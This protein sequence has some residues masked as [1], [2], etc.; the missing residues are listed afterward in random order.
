MGSIISS[1]GFFFWPVLAVLGASCWIFYKR[2]IFLKEIEQIEHIDLLSQ[3]QAYFLQGQLEKALAVTSQVRTPITNVLRAGLHAIHNGKSKEET[4]TA[5]DA[6]SLEE[7]PKL[8]EYN[9]LLVHLSIFSVLLGFVGFLSQG[10]SLLKTLP[11]LPQNERVLWVAQTWSMSLAPFY[12]GA[13]VS[14]IIWGGYSY[15]SW[16]YERKQDQLHSAALTV[17][18]LSLTYRDKLRKA[19]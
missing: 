13:L 7:I 19:S 8:T 3:I 16:K 15:F 12:W 1:S 11:E 9:S 6:A 14:A 18:H 2:W 4:Q 17:F 10:L 5:I